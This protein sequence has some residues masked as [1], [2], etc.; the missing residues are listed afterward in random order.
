MKKAAIRV[1]MIGHKFIPSRDGGVEVVVSNLAPHLA[2]IGYD[3][4]CYNRT[5]RQS[6][7][8]RKTG[9]LM[10]EYRGVRLV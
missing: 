7:K 3:V 5:S 6:R 1:A 8:L 2:E 10:R 9:E 4:T